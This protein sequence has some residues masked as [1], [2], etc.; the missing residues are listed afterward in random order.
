[1]NYGVEGH[2]MSVL[3]GVATGFAVA[4]RERANEVIREGMW[5][6]VDF[7]KALFSTRGVFIA[8]Y[9]LIGVFLNTAAPH[10]PT[11]PS[12]VAS[13]HS[14]VQYIISVFF[15]PLGLWHPTFIL[16]KWTP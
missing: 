16:G 3:P 1:M 15:W 14:W 5:A 8:V 6:E 11:T 10:L 12:S 13:F 9:I 7:L 4:C 2:G